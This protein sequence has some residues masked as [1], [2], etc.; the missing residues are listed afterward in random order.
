MTNNPL[1]WYVGFVKP[2]QERKCADALRKLGVICYLPVQKE[3]RKY[4][5]RIKEVERLVLPRMIFVRT[6]ETKRIPLLSEIYGLYAFMNEGGAYH[7]AIV[8]DR[9]LDDFRFMVEHSETRV[10]VESQLFMPGDR[11][12]VIAGPLKGLECELTSVGEKRCVAVRLGRVGTAL[13]E[14]PPSSLA[15]LEKTEK[16]EKTQ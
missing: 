9:E 11:V 15:L 4:S 1:H 8:P 2:Y 7:P 3:K 5:D 16:S 6:T 13:L 12:K 14:F 10:M